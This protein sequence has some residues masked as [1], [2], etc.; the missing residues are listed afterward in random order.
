MASSKGANRGVWFGALMRSVPLFFVLVAVAILF[1]ALA[2]A[3]IGP[4]PPWRAPL[5]TP[6]PNATITVGNTKLVVQLA[7][8]PDLQSL[9]LGY[10][11]GLAPDTGMLFVFGTP[12]VQ[13]FWMKG[14]RFCLDIVWVSDTRI[15]GA[16]ESVCPDPPGTPDSDRLVY[17]S[18]TPVRYVLEVPA[19]WLRAHGYGA[20]TP[21]NLSTL[22]SAVPATPIAASAAPRH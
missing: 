2:A 4:L 9:G 14:M 22:P 17:T 18:P 1:P 11:N 20:G 8:T 6:P 13:T 21:V 12:S 3:Q 16:A 5:A 10:R 15:A 19:G 7:V